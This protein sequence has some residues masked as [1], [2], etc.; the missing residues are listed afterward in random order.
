LAAIRARTSAESEECLPCACLSGRG[1]L[2][3]L[4]DFP[5]AGRVFVFRNSAKWTKAWEPVDDPMKQVD[6]VSLDETAKAGPGLAFGDAYA[7]L[8]PGVEVGLVPVARGSTSIHEWRRD[9]SRQTLYGSMVARAREA[10]DAGT[11]TGL[12]WYQG[13][14]DVADP[15]ALETWPRDFAQLVSDIRADLGRPNLP[16]VMTVIGPGRSG[17]TSPAW[18]AFQAMQE[19]MALPPNVARVSARDLA[20]SDGDIHLTTSSYVVLGRRYARAMHG[21]VE[22][23]AVAGAQ[24][25]PRPPAEQ[26]Q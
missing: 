18:A 7:A 13:E 22:A 14:T 16:V 24:A 9:L 2:D 17:E 5:E 20:V 8:V 25:A 6:L 12:L 10:S 23:P 21:L 3:E 15:Q 1:N 26:S 11:L 4:P 19:A